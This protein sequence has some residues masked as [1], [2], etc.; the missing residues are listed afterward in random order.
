MP[1]FS[2]AH[3]SISCSLIPVPETACRPR[4]R[5]CFSPRGWEQHAYNIPRRRPSAELQ[6]P[7]DHLRRAL[8]NSTYPSLS[9]HK[10]SFLPNTRHS[11]TR[12]FRPWKAGGRFCGNLG[13]IRRLDAGLWPNQSRQARASCWAFC[14][15]LF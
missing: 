5:L 9:S 1:Q 13:I 10:N 15:C 12:L 7:G 2:H 14:C 4:Y 3:W 6:V 11:G 8:G